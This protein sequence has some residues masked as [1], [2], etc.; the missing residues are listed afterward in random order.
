MKKMKKAA[1]VGFFI[2][3]LALV[4]CGVEIY[5]YPM[6]ASEGWSDS[7]SNSWNQP[8]SVKPSPTP[9]PSAK[10]AFNQNPVIT[11]FTANP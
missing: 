8:A 1:L 7:W 9:A 4:G 3:S 5:E 11:S 6:G 10:P 2:A